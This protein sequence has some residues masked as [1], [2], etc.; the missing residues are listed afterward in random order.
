MLGNR[1]QSHINIYMDHS[2]PSC[3]SRQFFKNVL[4]AQSL[5]SF[6]G[7][8]YVKRAAQK[9][10]AYQLN[11]NLLLSDQ[12][13]ANSKPNLEIFADDVKASHGATV[14]QLDDEQAF[15]LRTRGVSAQE[16]K[17]LL[18]IG[19]CRE[20]LDG[21][22]ISSLRDKLSRLCREFLLSQG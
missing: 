17:S 20:V 22:E 13:T 6:T 15:Y 9:T 16:A 19:F 3:I 5:S 10:E 7:K 8:I 18:T 11:Q 14:S 21:I 1:E 4:A 2:A 12:A